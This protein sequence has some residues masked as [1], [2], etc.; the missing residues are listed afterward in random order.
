MQIGLIGL[1]TGSSCARRSLAAG[2]AASVFIG[3]CSSREPATQRGDTAALE[4][5]APAS[6]TTSIADTLARICP[7]SGRRGSVLVARPDATEEES[8]V[9]FKLLGDGAGPGVVLC[10]D[11]LYADAA[12]LLG[13]MG[14]GG[15]VTESGG[16]ALIDSTRTTVP[17][18]MHGDIPYVAVAPFARYRRA[19]LVPSAD[20]PM[21]ATIWP[22]ETLLHLKTLGGDRRGL[23]DRAVSE[24]LF[25]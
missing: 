4:V 18:Y 22:R 24:G 6:R 9:T 10:R 7:D 19:L 25:R 8:Q 12:A 3:A 16:T 23:Y 2:M 5:E 15:T 17:A 11:V 21:D 13:M 1:P 14:E 20:H